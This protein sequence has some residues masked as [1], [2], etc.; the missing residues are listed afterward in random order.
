MP[1]CVRTFDESPAVAA[2]F[3]EGRDAPPH[4]P[5]ALNI[6]A[7]P[8]SRGSGD[9]VSEDDGQPRPEQQHDRERPRQTPS[10]AKEHERQ[11]PQQ[12][13]LLLHREGPEVFRVPGLPPQQAVC[14]AEER[15]QPAA[16][17]DRQHC[18]HPEHTNHQQVEQSGRLD[19]EQPPNIERP[20][21]DARALL[22]LVHQST[23]NHMAAEREEQMHPPRKLSHLARDAAQ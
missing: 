7:H 15:A 1:G 18:A 5:R 14:A 9:V 10:R 20:K 2:V 11:R 19:A 3:G 13:K 16:W 12:I 23:G 6:G 22:L 4:Q 17:R 8:H 21:T